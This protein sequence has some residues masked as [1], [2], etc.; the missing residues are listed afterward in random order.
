MSCRFPGGVARPRTC[1]ELVADGRRRDRRTSRPTAAGTSSG[2]T[3]PTRTSRAP[4][5]ARDGGF[6]HDAADFDAGVL[7]DLARARRWRWTR[8]SGCC[9]RR[10][11]R[12]SSGP[13]I[14]PASLRGSQHRRVRR[15]RSYHD[16]ARPAAPRRRRR[17]GLPAAPAPP[18]ASLSGRVAYTLGLE[19]PAVTV[20][21]AC[22]SSL[23]A[24]HLAAQALRAGECSLALAGGVTVMADARRRSSSSAGSAGW[25]PDGRCKAFA[26]ARRRHRLG[27]GR[28]AAAAGAA[29][30]RAPQRPPGA[31]GGARLARSTRTARPTA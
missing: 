8:S 4:R 6:L 24:L 31:R 10:P 22:S 11:G 18:A 26:A 30:G 15:R 17:R 28:R 25:P 5:Y 23:V 14:D 29:V 3:T 16:Y 1:G 9:W 2:S 12:R 27:R 21:T 20:D 19:G 13:G 7:R